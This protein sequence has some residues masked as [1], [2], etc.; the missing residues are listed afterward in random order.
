MFAGSKSTQPGVLLHT[1]TAVAPRLRGDDGQCN[2][3]SNTGTA[4]QSGQGVGVV[5]SCNNVRL[6]SRKLCIQFLP[7]NAFL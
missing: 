6:Q 3:Q 2:H 5:K 1:Q 4:M 7:H